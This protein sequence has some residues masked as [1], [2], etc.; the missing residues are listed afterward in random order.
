MDSPFEGRL[1]RL[2]AVEADDEARYHSWVNDP[3]VTENLTIRYPISHEGQRKWMEGATTP[4]YANAVFAVEALD[5]GALIGTAEL[6]T[7]RPENRDANLGI[8]IGDKTRWDHGYG[9]D[10]MRTI[11]RYGFS[12]MN[13]HRIELDVFEGNDRAVKVYE[14]VGF[15]PA[16]RRR[17]AV[18]QRGRYQDELMMD[19]LEGELRDG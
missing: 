11:C 15:K 19:L 17:D 12:E 8:M 1:I 9:S 4:D 3:E 2:R 13:L 16:G 7:R 10:A 6:R 18:F 5:D 14:R